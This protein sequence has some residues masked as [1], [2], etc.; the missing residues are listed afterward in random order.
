MNFASDIQLLLAV[1]KDIQAQSLAVRVTNAS[2]LPDVEVLD[3]ELYHS[4]GLDD[5]DYS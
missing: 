4:F 1:F 2:S 5:N 3:H